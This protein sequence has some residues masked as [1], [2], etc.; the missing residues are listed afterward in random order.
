MELDRYSESTTSFFTLDAC[1]GEIA[2][3]IISTL[4]KSD[5]LLNDEWS[6]LVAEN[7]E[8][9]NR[10]RSQGI[11][12]PGSRTSISWDD[13]MILFTCSIEVNSQQRPIPLG[14]QLSKERFGRFPWG[15][16]SAIVYLID[17]LRPNTGNSDGSEDYERLIKLLNKLNSYCID[18]PFGDEKY[19][20]GKGG[21]CIC[22][23]LDKSEVYQLRKYLTG[24]IWSVSADEPLDGGV[25]DAIKHF[26]SILKSAERR[27][28]GTM[29]RAHS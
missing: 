21:L 27:G 11:D 7:D 25:R 17:F 10:I 2:E 14:E 13:A 22:G 8:I 18:G 26:V 9:N 24:R 3:K 19:R 12:N 6:R 4:S 20:S 16:G 15:S 1:N 5:D 23:F 28:V 29:L